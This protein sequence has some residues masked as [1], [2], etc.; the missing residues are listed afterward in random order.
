MRRSKRYML[1]QRPDG[2]YFVLYK[3]L[4][5]W[6]RLSEPVGFASD[7]FMRT[8]PLSFF[9]ERAALRA[10]RKHAGKKTLVLVL[11]EFRAI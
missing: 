3:W 8:A 7:G 2:T 4:F 10:I 5:L 11:N 9:S 1:L 6:H